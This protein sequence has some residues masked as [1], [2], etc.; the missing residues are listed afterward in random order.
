[1]LRYF[2]FCGLISLLFLNCGPSKTERP[3]KLPIYGE[4]EIV[5]G[6]TIY[7]TIPQY[8]FVNQDSQAVT[9]ATFDGKAYV[10]DYFFT[11]CPTICPKVKQQMLRMADRF[12][13]ED[14]LKILSVSI[15]TKYDTI[16]RL[17]WYADKLEIKTD[18]WH[19]VTG[20][21]ELIYTIDEDFFHVAEEDPDAPGGYNH[22][23]RLILIDQEHHIRA[24]CDGTD[25]EDV[26]DFMDDI[27]I[28][29][30]EMDGTN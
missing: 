29:M 28:L 26:D 12:Q 25:A 1:M 2:L 19:L 23:G 8:E 22:D 5:E 7:H 6:D 4:K 3:S 10:V 21:K 24:F 16:P 18:Q 9:K 30:R 15:D 14:R 27:D 17:K 20:D 11:S 13:E